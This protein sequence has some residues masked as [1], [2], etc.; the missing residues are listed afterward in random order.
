MHNT[1]HPPQRNS[2][3]ILGLSEEGIL[4]LA[5]VLYAAALFCGGLSAVIGLIVSYI[6]RGDAERGLESSLTLSHTRWQIRTF[7]LGLIWALACSAASLL[8]ALSVVGAVFIYPL[9]LILL[10]WYAY[11]LI[12]GMLALN[13]GRDIL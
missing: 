1:P 5:Y 2:G 3:R 10:V 9:W 7:W 11:R 6:K 12:K 4:W 13:S 8:F